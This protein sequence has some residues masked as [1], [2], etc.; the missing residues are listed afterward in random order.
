MRVIAVVVILAVC[1]FGAQGA[2]ALEVGLRVPL[3]GFASILV[4]DQLR[5]EASAVIPG[6][7]APL[8]DFEG[9]LTA[10]LYPTLLEFSVSE[11]PLR[12]F[13]GGGVT[14]LQAMRRWVPGLVGVVGVETPAPGLDWPVTILLEG[15]GTLL[16]SEAAPT[17]VFELSL[18]ARYQF[19]TP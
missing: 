14:L 8:V 12:P 13:V 15:S 1:I 10:K 11:L 18:G 9:R 3:A 16:M 17:L 19:T 5:V 4:G 7:S 6:F 2:S